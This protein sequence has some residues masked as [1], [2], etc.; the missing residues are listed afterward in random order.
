MSHVSLDSPYVD[1]E[2]LDIVT[3]KGSE[4]KLPHLINVVLC[5]LYIFS[6][7]FKLEEETDLWKIK[8]L[9]SSVF[10]I[11]E[12]SPSQHDLETDKERITKKLRQICPKVIEYKILEVMSW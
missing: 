7:S 10:S 6:D 9:L 2:F 11:H 3:K 4:K 5:V 8:K 12:E 1:V